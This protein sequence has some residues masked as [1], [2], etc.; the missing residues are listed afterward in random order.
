VLAIDP[1]LLLLDEITSGLDPASSARL[2]D[3]LASLPGMAVVTATHNLSIAE[4][5]G[6]RAILLHPAGAGI[7]HDG[8]LAALLA[9]E[10]LLVESGLAH[11]HAH[12]HGK[13]AHAHWHL[14]DPE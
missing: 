2:V 11:R 4:E 6:E 7:L 5:L 12:R 14:H 13:R 10:S 3:L 8:P 1:R 9:D